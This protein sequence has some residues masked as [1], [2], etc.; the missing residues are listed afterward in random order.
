MPT[1]RI[2][3]MLGQANIGWSETWWLTRST[4][5]AA[6][7]IIQQEL[8]NR[9]DM[10]WDIQYWTGVR[11]AQEGLKRQSQPFLP[12]TSFW[13]DAGANIVVPAV[14]SIPFSDSVDVAPDQVRATL[15]LRCQFDVGRTSLRYLSGVPD[16]VTR[17][18][19]R[20]FQLGG[21]GTAWVGRYEAWRN[22]LIANGWALRAKVVHPTNPE[23]PIQDMV[24]Q[25]AEPGYVGVSVLTGDAL[26]LPP[27]NRVWIKGQRRKP[28]ATDKRTMNGTWVVS[29]VNP[30]LISGRVVYFLRNSQGIDPEQ[31]RFL[32]TV[33]AAQYGFYPVTDIRIYKAGIHKRGR[34]SGAPVGRRKSR[35]SLDP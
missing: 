25:A 7:P 8:T 16:F 29:S 2:T 18:E 33:Q 1:Y 9:R 10:M 17:T 15:Q 6:L 14:G 30:T 27:D 11:I 13:K 5:S 26:S 31:F 19:P 3:Q 35:A 34:P 24:L 20:T 28:S 4:A 23:R 21:A 32:G 12:G 22:N